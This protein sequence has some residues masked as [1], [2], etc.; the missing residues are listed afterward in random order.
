MEDIKQKLPSTDGVKR[1]RVLNRIDG[2]PQ[3]DSAKCDIPYLKIKGTTPEWSDGQPCDI[4][5]LPEFSRLDGH[6]LQILDDTGVPIWTT[7]K[8]G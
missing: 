8:F 2:I 1:Y 7:L 4:D 5:G 6:V 3:W